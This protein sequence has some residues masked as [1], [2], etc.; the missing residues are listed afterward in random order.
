MVP[1]GWGIARACR[2]PPIFS[3]VKHRD[4]SRL[5][6]EFDRVFVSGRIALLVGWEES[7]DWRGKERWMEASDGR[8]KGAGLDSDVVHFSICCTVAIPFSASPSAPTLSPSTL[9]DERP[10]AVLRW[11]GNGTH[12]HYFACLNFAAVWCKQLS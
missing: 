7:I 8:A 2:F 3:C 12:H 5:G 6:R 4:L 10:S 1:A 11:F 9:I